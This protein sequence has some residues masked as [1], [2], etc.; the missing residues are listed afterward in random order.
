MSPVQM[1]AAFM[2]ICL[3]VLFVHGVWAPERK[4]VAG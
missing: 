1:L 4:A 3:I 2:G